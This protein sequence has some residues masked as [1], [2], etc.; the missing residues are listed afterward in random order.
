MRLVKDCGRA[1]DNGQVVGAMLPDLSKAFD[2][3]PHDL[4]VAKLKAYGWSDKAVLLIGD[5]LSNC[6][7]LIM[8]ISWCT[9]NYQTNHKKIISTDED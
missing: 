3:M 6:K 9:V 5:Y 7:Q 1:L 4:L 2:A 8:T